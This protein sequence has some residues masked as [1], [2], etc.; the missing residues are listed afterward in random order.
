MQVGATNWQ[1]LTNTYTTYTFPITITGTATQSSVEARTENTVASRADINSTATTETSVLVA[2][3]V[4][5]DANSITTTETAVL[6][7]GGPVYVAGLFKTTYEGYFND[8]L[9][10]FDDATPAAYG[11]NPATE[12]QT[13]QIYESANDD[14]EGFSVQWLGYFKPTTTETYTFTLGSDDSSFMWIG[15]T[16]VTG[17]DT[18]NPLINNGGDHGYQEFSGSIALNAGQYYP[19]RIMFGENGGDDILTFAYQTPT[20]GQTGNVTGL[21]FYNSATNGF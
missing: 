18:G 17:F 3:G 8:Y 12:V 21:V 4:T 16:A 5:S 1:T 11:S 13:T 2:S 19:V 9:P 10:F 20:I 7:A 15:S 14:G 6:V